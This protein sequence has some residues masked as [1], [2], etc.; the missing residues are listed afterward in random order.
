MCLLGVP[1]SKKAR[2]AMRDGGRVRGQ[3]DSKLCHI[4]PCRC[5]EALGFCT[6]VITLAAETAR[7]QVGMEKQKHRLYLGG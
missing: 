7:L 3:K 4:G 6:S 2:I 5:G 1:T